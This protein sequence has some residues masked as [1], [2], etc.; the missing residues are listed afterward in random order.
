MELDD[1][2]KLD[3]EEQLEIVSYYKNLPVEERQEISFETHLQDYTKCEN[4]GK[5]V[6][7]SYIDWV[8]EE[9]ICQD[10]Q[11]DGYGE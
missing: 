10:C 11:N 8:G 2:I 9:Q 7:D 1:F 5:W 4:C 6:I 3:K